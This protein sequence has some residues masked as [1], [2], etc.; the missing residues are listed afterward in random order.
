MEQKHVLPYG[1]YIA[2][3]FGLLMLTGITITAAGLHFGHWSVMAAILI[4]TIKGS[5][6]LFYFMHLK[7]EDTVFR[8]MLTVALLTLAVIMAL[9]FADVAFR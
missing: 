4:A 3:W 5:L 8:I 6:V 1:T 9:T 2:I 7:Y